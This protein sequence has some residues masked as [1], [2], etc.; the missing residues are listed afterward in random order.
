MISGKKIIVLLSVL[1]QFQTVGW[2]QAPGD[3]F[4]PAIPYDS[5]SAKQKLTLDL[6]GLVFFRNNEF[7]NDFVEGYTLP[8]WWMQPSLTYHFSE[9]T[10][11]SAGINMLKFHGHEGF[12][13]VQPVLTFRHNFTPAFFLQ[14]G[15][16]EGHLH[17]GL[18]E[19]LYG[20]ERALTQNLEQGIQL[21]YEGRKLFADFWVNWEQF[22]WFGDTLQE[23]FS[24]GLST[25]IAL[26]N[27]GGFHFSLPVYV[28][29]THQGGQINVSNRSI[30]TLMNAASG[31]EISYVA[32]DSRISSV[33]LRNLY[34]IYQNNSSAIRQAFNEGDAFYS[35]L[36]LK[37]KP[38]FME[39]GYWRGN[40][41][42]APRGEPLFMSINT[43]NSQMNHTKR[44][45]LTSRLFISANVHKQVKLGA[46]Y[47]LYYG[48]L[49]KSLDYYYGVYARVDLSVPL[50]THRK[51]A[52]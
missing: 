51:T 42:V 11:L 3:F 5:L 45:L 16:L 2:T 8:G 46:E 36:E 22:I 50:M 13:D 27:T 25:K 29:F 21:Q 33:S 15:N 49:Q 19:P 52:F 9:I 7:F 17:H 26:F 14:I 41:F 10:K 6:E 23:Q 30:E 40:T 43:E 32:D 44:E 48:M 34:F 35:T 47:A 37:M 18:P 20:Y 4:A 1:V 12:F 24:A 38:G 39:L 31:L 28:L